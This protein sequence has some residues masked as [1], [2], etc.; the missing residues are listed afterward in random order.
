M[1]VKKMLPDAIPWMDVRD[2]NEITQVAAGFFD[3]IEHDLK[4]K[5]GALQPFAEG[6]VS[7]IKFLNNA[8]AG[9]KVPE[10][11]GAMQPGALTT[12]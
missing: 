5:G 11:A 3:S 2:A 4:T 10:Q 1:L 12:A 8:C 7:S 6:D 9:L